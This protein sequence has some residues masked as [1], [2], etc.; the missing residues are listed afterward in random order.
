MQN[1]DNERIHYH[2]AFFSTG[3]T[4]GQHFTTV[5]FIRYPVPP[6][7]LF[8]K[9]YLFYLSFIFVE[10]KRD[11]SVNFVEFLIS[12]TRSSDTCILKPALIE[13]ILHLSPQTFVRLFAFSPLTLSLVL[14]LCLLLLLCLLIFHQ[15]FFPISHF[16][17][18]RFLPC[19]FFF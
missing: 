16:F 8:L 4:R 10:R 13:N 2:N 1:T 12:R 19:F 17:F 14:F 9:I 11:I 7:D 15:I 3:L 6:I 5:F 18:T